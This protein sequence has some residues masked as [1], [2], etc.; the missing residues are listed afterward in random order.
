MGQFHFPQKWG[1][2]TFIL[3]ST[4]SRPFLQCGWKE[5]PLFQFWAC[6]PLKLIFSSRYHHLQKGGRKKQLKSGVAEITCRPLCFSHGPGKSSVAPTSLPNG[7]GVQGLTRLAARTCPDASQSTASLQ[8]Q[9][10]WLAAS[11]WQRLWNS[12]FINWLTSTD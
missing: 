5:L 2:G 8:L 3:E 11:E 1:T 9:L 7:L 6:V 10:V 4:D 12:F